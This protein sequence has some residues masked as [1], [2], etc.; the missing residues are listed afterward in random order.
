MQIYEKRYD[1]YEYLIVYLF[2][3]EKMKFFF[4]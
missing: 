1:P 4:I 3:Q 2:E